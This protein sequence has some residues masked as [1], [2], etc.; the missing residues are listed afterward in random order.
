MLKLIVL[1]PLLEL[2]SRIAYRNDPAPLSLVVVTVN[3][4]SIPITLTG[5][6]TVKT[7]IKTSHKMDREDL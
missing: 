7:A 6:H 5:R 3:V 1:K 4:N 2:A